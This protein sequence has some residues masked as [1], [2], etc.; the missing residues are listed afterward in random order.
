M[1]LATAAAATT[2]GS[3]PAASAS[4]GHS[5]GRAI[6]NEGDE[7]AADRQQIDQGQF[8]RNAIVKLISKE[9]TS[10]RL[11]GRQPL[12]VTHFITFRQRE[13]IEERDLERVV[14]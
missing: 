5:G 4:H 1:S 8:Q 7:D 11:A 12:M 6:H 13:D 3:V 2:A 9:A 10:N 14:R